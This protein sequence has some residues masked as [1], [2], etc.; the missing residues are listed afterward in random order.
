MC[1]L[2]AGRCAVDRTARTHARRPSHAEVGSGLRVVLRDGELGVGGREEAEGGSWLGL[3]GGID[4]FGDG[5]CRC[6][7]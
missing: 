4:V 1:V 7:C 6:R 2:R 3:A 5:G